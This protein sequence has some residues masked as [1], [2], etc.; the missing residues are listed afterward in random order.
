MAGLTLNSVLRS[1]LRRRYPVVR[2]YDRTDCGPAALLSVLKFWG[3][4]ASLVAVRELA[5]TDTNGTT[6]LA[7]L[8]AAERLGFRASGAS[9][10]YDEL[11][12]VA[13][14]CVAHVVMDGILPHYVVVYRVGAK[15][16]L[17]GDP[18]RGI[19]R[20][21]RSDFLAIWVTRSV[22][23]LSPTKELHHSP[24]PH[25]VRWIVSYFRRQGAWVAQSVFLG[26][27]YTVLGLLT[28]VF[29][30]LLI[31]RFI[32]ER[33]ASAVV[34]TGI[35]LLG[36]QVLRA[37]VGY[38]RRRV[39]LELN[40]RVSTAVAAD[41]VGHL[42]KLPTRFFESRRTGDIT[43]RLN[44]SVRIQAAVLGIVGST[45]VDVLVVVGSMTFLFVLT[46][47]L[48]WIA[49]ATV[50]LY[51]TMLSLV[52]R[53]I[54]SEQHEAMQSYAQVEASYID[55]L[56]SI[57][58]IRSFNSG[59]VFAALI[60]KL[61]GR[62]Q[63]RVAR[64][65][66]TQARVGLYAEL[67][68][69]LLVMTA[70]TAGAMLVIGGSI[71]LGQM[72]AAYSLFAGMIPATVR[73]VEAHLTV[74]EA[75]VA[76][77]RLMD[78]LLVEPESA[79]GTKPFRLRQALTVR[80]GRFEWPKGDRLF[81]GLTLSIECGRLTAL[82]GA[83]G[84][85]KSTLVKILERKYALTAGEVRV[86]DVM[87]SEIDLES[88]RRHV[89]ALPEGVKIITGTIADNVLLGRTV[90][91]LDDVTRRIDELGLASF[92]ARFPSGLLTL[93]GEGGRKLSSGERQVIGL[94]RALLEAPTVLLVDEGMNTADVETARAMM[95]TLTAYARDHAVLVVSHQLRTLLHADYLYVMGQ[96]GV[97]EEGVPRDLLTGPT[98]F[99]R[100]MGVYDDLAVS[101]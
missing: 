50:P 26:V 97:I 76:A 15:G 21:R 29:V 80:D 23:L 88:Y 75:S 74:Q 57:E 4:D 30:Q 81:E 89:T 43:A 44:D 72:M 19:V 63:E 11:G 2:Q 25:W 64:L 99:R 93:V 58:A 66:K 73:M 14:P 87:V 65:G 54:Q 3:G 31:D 94:M 38:I 62:F 27:A 48:G 56:T 91:A 45:V 20:M 68:G 37:G 36:V 35:F 53:R 69:G 84:V 6:L 59:G 51:V 46:P 13:L 100:L 24:A 96:G 40:R 9:G 47:E 92:L 17:L 18:A 90:D 83:T 95:R 10:D 5:F 98:E 16:V 52:T 42:F 101:A 7:L 34:A 82:C 70:L 1:L 79:P 55:G 28:A 61:Y 12:T 39:L 71:T 32:P 67:A 77:R 33:R 60:G 86:D 8:R 85:G 49:L 22:L 41:S 78:L